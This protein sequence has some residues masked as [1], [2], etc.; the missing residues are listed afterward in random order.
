MTTGPQAELCRCRKTEARSGVRPPPRR[1]PREPA[2]GAGASARRRAHGDSASS[3][4]PARRPR[5]SAPPRRRSP[6]SATPRRPHRPPD[7]LLQGARGGTAARGARGAGAGGAAGGARRRRRPRG[8]RAPRGGRAGR[9]PGGAT[10]SSAA[11]GHAR[12]C[13]GGE[14]G[15]GTPDLAGDGL[16]GL[17]REKGSKGTGGGFSKRFVFFFLAAAVGS[18]SD[19]FASTRKIAAAADMLRRVRAIINLDFSLISLPNYL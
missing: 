12:A 14:V 18:Q 8:R 6:W 10:S 9:G 2:R 19:G 3:A 17:L 5:W 16:C 7:Q 15:S 1:S 13:S 11:A 4:P